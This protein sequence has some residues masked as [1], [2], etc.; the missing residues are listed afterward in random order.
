MTRSIPKIL[1]QL[2]IGPKPAPTK[3]MQTWK[4]KHPSF[5]YIL[6][7]DVEIQR[8]GM[9]FRCQKQIDAMPEWNGK[10]DIMRWEILAKYGGYFVDA[11]SICIEPFDDY[12][13]GCPAFACFENETVRKSLIATGTMGFCPGYP[14][15]LDIIHWIDSPDSKETFASLRAWGSVGPHAITRFLKSGKYSDFAIYPSHCFLPIHYTDDIYHGH[16]K[17]Y[18]YQLWGN[19][20]DIYDNIEQIELPNCFLPPPFWVSVLMPVYQC[21]ALFLKECFESILQQKGYF[22]IEL[23][24]VNDGSSPEYTAILEKELDNFQRKSRF[25]RVVYLSNVEN[26]GVAYSLRLGVEKCS[27]ELIFRM[28]ADDI[29]LPERVKTQIEFFVNHP[30]CVI[31]GTNMSMFQNDN[32]KELSQKTLLKT[33]DH[34]AELTWDDFWKTVPVWF[35]NHPT[36]CFRKSAV[37][38]VGNYDVEMNGFEDYELELRLMKR[39]IKVYNIEYPLVMYRVHKDQITATEGSETKIAERRNQCLSI[40]RLSS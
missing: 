2:W 32:L 14:L 24:C 16:K 10:A 39:F 3:M 28:D 20:R 6:W 19:T 13:E 22:G 33:T 35:M 27:N 15:C 11:D 37:L 34:P 25:C 17:V 18:A 21:P 26:R 7:N 38:E 4:D 29:M 23:V 5:E 31:C 1:H 9:V 40:M 8:R 36:L 12:F 30:T